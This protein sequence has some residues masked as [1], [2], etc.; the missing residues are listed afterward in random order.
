MHC[1]VGAVQCSAVQCGAV[2]VLV[3]V[4]CSAVVGLAQPAPPATQATGQRH[5]RQPWVDEMHV[6][7]TRSKFGLVTSFAQKIINLH[8]GL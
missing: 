1:T 4:Q 2:L 8:R 7:L 5:S 6:K 3:L